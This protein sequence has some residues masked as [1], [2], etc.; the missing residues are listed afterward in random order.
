M[1]TKNWEKNYFRGKKTKLW[2]DFLFSFLIRKK[3]LDITHM[4]GS[5]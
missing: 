1:K 4:E 5:S 2:F 3:T